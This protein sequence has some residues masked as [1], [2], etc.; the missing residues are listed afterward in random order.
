MDDKFRETWKLI[1]DELIALLY[2][3]NVLPEHCKFEKIEIFLDGGQT[4]SV[5]IEPPCGLYITELIEKKLAFEKDV[6]DILVRYQII[7]QNNFIQ[8]LRIG[9]L[10]FGTGT[11]IVPEFTIRMSLPS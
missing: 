3:Y 2:K 1:E 5:S 8:E 10:C 7:P 11:V 4:P 6:V 9:N